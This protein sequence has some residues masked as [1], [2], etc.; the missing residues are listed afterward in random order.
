M[1][2]PTLFGT[3][4][5]MLLMQKSSAGKISTLYR[6]SQHYIEHFFFD[7]DYIRISHTHIDR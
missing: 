2:S 6:S 4:S 3:Q 5:F 1:K 7:K